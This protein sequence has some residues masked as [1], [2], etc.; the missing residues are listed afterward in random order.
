MSGT[1]SPPVTRRRFLGTGVAAAAGA[2]AGGVAGGGYFHH[3]AREQAAEFLSADFSPIQP[4][5][6]LLA[7]PSALPIM[8]VPIREKSSPSLRKSRMEILSLRIRHI[9]LPAPKRISGRKRPRART[10]Q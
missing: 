9:M 8:A 5:T 3:R 7:S 2:A 4:S 6:S 1:T 10:I